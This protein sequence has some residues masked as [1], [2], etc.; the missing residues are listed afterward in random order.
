MFE[1]FFNHQCDIYHLSDSIVNAGYGIKLEKTKRETLVAGAKNVPC[2]FYVKSNSI[3]VISK[4][5]YSSIEGEI[6]LSLP[7][8]TDILKNDI[9]MSHETGLYYRAGLPRR[10][11]NHHITIILTREDGLKGAI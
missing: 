7:I 3:K 4:E 2:H 11:Q 10:I 9:I 6:K 5:P 1:D 8:G